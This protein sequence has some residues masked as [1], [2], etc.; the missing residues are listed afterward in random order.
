MT[1]RFYINHGSSLFFISNAYEEAKPGKPNKVFL[2]NH[3]C[4]M[5]RTRGFAYTVH[6]PS[7][8]SHTTLKN[9]V[10][11]LSA[12]QSFYIRITAKFD[13]FSAF[14]FYIMHG[15]SLLFI[16]KTS[17]TDWTEKVTHNYFVLFVT[18]KDD[19]R[20]AFRWEPFTYLVLFIAITHVCPF[21]TPFTHFA[22]F[23]PFT[24]VVFFIQFTIFVFLYTTQIL[25][26]FCLFHI[27]FLSS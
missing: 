18:R 1:V 15:S 3:Y 5:L 27:L 17:Q 8:L 25:S 10:Y 20:D 26:R 7:L 9:R 24:Q 2:H 22:H 23:I 19:Q 13:V 16:T 14:R 12:T 6:G 11:H 21:F 4:E